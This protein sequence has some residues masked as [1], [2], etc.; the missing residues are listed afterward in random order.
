MNA[1][2]LTCVFF[3]AA[4]TLS[5]NW[6]KNLDVNHAV[7]FAILLKY[8]SG[9]CADENTI[10]TRRFA[11]NSQSIELFYTDSSRARYGH[12]GPAASTPTHEREPRKPQDLV[13]SGPALP[14]PIPC[15]LS[16]DR[17]PG[18]EH[19]QR[20]VHCEGSAVGRYRSITQPSSTCSDRCILLFSYFHSNLLF[21]CTQNSTMKIKF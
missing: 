9:W 11:H 17:I 19:S 4:D 5:Q 21:H 12:G 14:V 15:P 7:L 18:S 2:R 6:R 20:L 16:P 10:R 3:S 13:T 1:A 8:F